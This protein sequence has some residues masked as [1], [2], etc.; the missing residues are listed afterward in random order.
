MPAFSKLEDA[1]RKVR[2]A[3]EREAEQLSIAL[4]QGAPEAYAS[5]HRAH[6]DLIDTVHRLTMTMELVR[7]SR[8]MRHRPRAIG[9][10]LPFVNGADASTPLQDCFAMPDAVVYVFSPVQ[11]STESASA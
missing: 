10:S 8:G 7:R 4:D 9:T 11:G 3:T 6:L 2:S 1:I 5:V